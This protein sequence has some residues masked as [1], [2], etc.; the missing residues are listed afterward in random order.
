M[1]QCNVGWRY[2]VQKNSDIN[3][4]IYAYKQANK[5]R[6]P[7]GNKEDKKLEPI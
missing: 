5:Y 7:V 6:K 3:K 2:A 1:N 4:Y